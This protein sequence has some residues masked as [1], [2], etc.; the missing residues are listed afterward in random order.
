[1]KTMMENRH[2]AKRS[3]THDAIDA[4]LFFDQSHRI[5]ITV[6]KNVEISHASISFWRRAAKT[7]EPISSKNLKRPQAKPEKHLESRRPLPASIKN[8][9]EI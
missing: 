6:Y 9:L 7:L 1:M 8:Q 5:E 3:H 2:T 4:W